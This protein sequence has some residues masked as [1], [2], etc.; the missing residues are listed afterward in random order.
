VVAAVRDVGAAY[1]FLN[2]VDLA[3]LA[4]PLRKQVGERCRIIL[5]SHGLESADYLHTL[6]SA[7]GNGPFAKATRG[8]LLRLARQLVAECGQRQNIDHVFCLAPF[9]VEIERWLGAKSV[10][11]LPR[12]ILGS[13]LGWKPDP[14]RLGFVGTLDHPPNREGLELFLEALQP[15]APPEVR[16]RVIGSPSVTA[17]ALKRRFPLLEYLGSLSDEELECEA[18]TWSC[19]V[20]PIFCYARGCSTK[21]AIALGWQIPVATT[22]A[23]CRGYTWQ[24]GN[25]PLAESPRELAAL[26]LKLLDEN[27]ARRAV[28]EVTAVAD[29]SPT[30]VEVAGKVRRCLLLDAANN[31]IG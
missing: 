16:L 9:E 10:D 13:A 12:T 8:G 14:T 6:R 17:A 29:S 7:G 2:V 18:R 1:V 15:M 27:E 31:H 26:A 22:P 30:L 3:P 23:G 21:L 11:W 25:L 19:F 20:H 28:R 4:L 24:E 5:L